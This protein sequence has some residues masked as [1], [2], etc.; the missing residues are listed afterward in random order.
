MARNRQKGQTIAQMG[1]WLS[2]WWYAWRSGGTSRLLLLLQVGYLVW[3]LANAQRRYGRPA[4][5]PS[6][7]Y[8]SVRVTDRRAASSALMSP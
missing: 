4:D 1:Y 6:R 3:Y 8:S 2:C 7:K 5:C